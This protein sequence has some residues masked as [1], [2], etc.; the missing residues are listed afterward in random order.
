MCCVKRRGI[1]LIE[2]VGTL[3]LLGV[4]FAITVPMLLAVAR[5]R[6][7]SQQRQFALQHAANLLEHPVTRRWQELEPGEL[8][9]PDAPSDLR[10]ILPGLE[11]TLTV[12]DVAAESAC[13]QIT[14]VVRWQASSGDWASP[15]RL[16]TW[17]YSPKEVP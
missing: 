8:N 14:A 4:M 12:Q 15:V 10:T 13:R 11:R 5:E 9:L 1:S 6:Q 3:T 7:A 2:M 17:V 16:C